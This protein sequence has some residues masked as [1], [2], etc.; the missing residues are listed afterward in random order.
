MG[1]FETPAETIFDVNLIVQLVLIIFLATGVMSRR[2]RKRHGIIMASATLANLTTIF[3]IM[4]PSLIR[5]FGVIIADPLST[6]AMITVAHSILGATTILLGLLFTFR[7]LS[8]TRGSRPLV[9]GKR[10]MMILTATLWLLSLSD[11]IAFYVYYYA[12]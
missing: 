6:G 2:I 1:I 8:A 9:C 11:G 3:L 4:A 12:L 5:N 7:F 10:R